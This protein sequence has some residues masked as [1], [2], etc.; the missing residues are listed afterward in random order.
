MQRRKFL[1]G[2]G[3]TAIGGSALLG[4]GAFSRVESDRDV[5]IQVA[6]DS[7]AYVG[8]QQKETPNSQNYTGYD[9]KGHFFIDI[10]DQG[11]F[12]EGVN[13]DSTTYFDDLFRLCNQGKED[14]YF[15]FD[16]SELEF[17]ENA[18]VNLYVRD[19]EDGFKGS[20]VCPGTHPETGENMEGAENV[21]GWILIPVGQC[22][23][24][25]LKTYTYSVDATQEGPLVEGTATVIAD[26]EDPEEEPIIEPPNNNA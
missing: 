8:L 11:G 12:G 25:G 6:H 13:S 15:C 24:V 14:A 10:A 7:E 9:E 17:A 26:V 21:G 18:V 5:M 20:I 3:G 16:F 2:V 4:S 23:Q 19:E 1:I 22:V